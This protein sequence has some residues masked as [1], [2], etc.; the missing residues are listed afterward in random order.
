MYK[1]VLAISLCLMACACQTITREQC[2]TADWQAVGYEEG[3]KGL[4]IDNFK[5]HQDACGKHGIVP[6]REQYSQGH[7]Q[8]L[9]LY[10]EP[11]NGFM[12][13]RDGVEYLEV[14]T[15]NQ[16]LLFLP[17]Y[18]EGRLIGEHERELSALHAIKRSLETEI[19]N[20]DRRSDSRYFAD[21][22]RGERPTGID[23]VLVAETMEKEKQELKQAIQRVSRTIN[24][25]SAHI[26]SMMAN[27]IFLQ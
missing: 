2:Q 9:A 22:S 24:E 17:A 18:N 1:P 10:C 4:P 14:C 3:V 16:E 11:V 8:G 21:L 12:Q 27:T 26:E 23:S 15:A 19:R 7:D 25:L 13:G 5:S 6:P 20:I